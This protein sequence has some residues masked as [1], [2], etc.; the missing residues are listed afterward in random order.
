MWF[1][2]LNLAYYGVDLVTLPFSSLDLNNKTVIFRRGK[3]DIHRAGILWA[4]TIQAIKDYQ[5][6]KPHRGST[7]FLNLQAKIP[8]SP[9][10]IYKKFSKLIK[11]LELQEQAKLKENKNYSV[12]KFDYCH[13]NF[14]NS[15]ESVCAARSITSVYFRGR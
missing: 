2:S 11:S 7:L 3:T 12:V 10:R 15:F 13:S 9:S 1:L 4:E 14:R 8:Y 5:K 6:E